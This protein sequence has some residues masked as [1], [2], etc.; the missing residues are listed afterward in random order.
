MQKKKTKLLLV[1]AV[2]IGGLSGPLAAN[3]E[4]QS[5]ST[6]VTVRF[7][8]ETGVQDPDDNNNYIPST[9]TNKKGSGFSGLPSAGSKR[10]PVT[11]DECNRTLSSLGWLTLLAAFM[12]YL[13]GKTRKEKDNVYD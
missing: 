2:V 5:Q 11:G 10:L 6:E 9:P 1:A 7:A 12:F 13:L 4:T 8:E 3:A